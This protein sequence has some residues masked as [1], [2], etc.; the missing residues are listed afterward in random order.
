MRMPRIS[1]SAAMCICAASV[2]ACQSAPAR[3]QLVVRSAGIADAGQSLRYT[4]EMRNSDVAS[5][6]VATCAERVLPS[7]LY[8]DGNRAGGVTTPMCERHELRELRPG[9]TLRDSGTVVRQV[10]AEYVPSVSISR[11]ASGSTK[12]VLRGGM[13]IAP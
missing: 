10:G 4:L 3:V 1:L 8:R 5:V 2:V 9:V 6:W 11:S 12:Q 13:F 7:F